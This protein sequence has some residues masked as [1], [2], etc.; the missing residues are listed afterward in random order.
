VNIGDYINMVLNDEEY[1]IDQA[2]KFGKLITTKYAPYQINAHQDVNDLIRALKTIKIIR[3]RIKNDTGVD[4]KSKIIV[5][6]GKLP[7]L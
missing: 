7:A 6:L 3:A 5:W 2:R 1:L 4:I